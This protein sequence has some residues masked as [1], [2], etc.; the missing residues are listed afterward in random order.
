MYIIHIWVSSTRTRTLQRS[1]RRR[2]ESVRLSKLAFAGL[3]RRSFPHHSPPLIR[4]A[5]YRYLSQLSRINNTTHPLEACPL[6]WLVPKGRRCRFRVSRWSLFPD[7]ASTI[8]TLVCEDSRQQLLGQGRCRRHSAAGSH[9][10]C[11]SNVGGT[12]GL[13]PRYEGSPSG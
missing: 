3:R 13:L 2:R 10:Q 9:A 4:A 6:A 8:L 7:W 1:R 12:K 5:P 11:Q